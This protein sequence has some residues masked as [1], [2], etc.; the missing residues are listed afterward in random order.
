MEE[1][2]QMSAF[3]NIQQTLYNH[4]NKQTWGNKIALYFKKRKKTHTPP[5]SDISFQKGN[6]LMELSA[7]TS[8]D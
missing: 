8:V 1:L 6:D 7:D 4:M 5:P 3:S 2:T